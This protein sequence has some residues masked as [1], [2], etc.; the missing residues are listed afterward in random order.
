MGAPGPVLRRSQARLGPPAL[1]VGLLLLVMTGPQR[2]RFSPWRVLAGEP[3]RSPSADVVAQRN[4][5]LE[6]LAL[7]SGESVIDIGCGPAF[8]CD[9]MAEAVG[10]HGRV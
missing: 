10:E 4:A 7:R 1:L 3:R 2:W 6:R 9:E 8:L 5:T